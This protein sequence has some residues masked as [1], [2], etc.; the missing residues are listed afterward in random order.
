MATWFAQNSSVNIDSVNQWNSAANGSGSWLTWASLAAGDVLVANGKTSIAINVNVTCATLTTAATGGTAGGGFIL[1]AGVNITAN[2]DCGTTT[3]V[4][5]SAAGGSNCIITG[6]LTGST[7]TGSVTAYWHSSTGT[8]NIVGNVVGGTSSGFGA[9]VSNG[10]VNITGNVT[11]GGAGN[12]CYGINYSA[13]SLAITGNVTGGTQIYSY[14]ILAA[15]SISIVIVGDII[16]S[17]T[18][19][20]IGLVGAVLGTTTIL[21]TG[22][23]QGSSGGIVPFGGSHKYLIHA[24]NAQQHGYYTN[25]SGTPGVLRTLYTG[26]VNL[27]QPAVANVRSGTTFGAASEYT[28]TLAVPSASLVAVGV[29]TD[30]TTGTYNPQ[31][32]LLIDT[33]IAT[34]ASQT[35]F[36][37]TA[38]SADDDTYNDKTMIITD[39]VTSA[40]KA[41]VTVSDY[42]GSTKTITLSAS[43][44]FTIATGDYVAV[45]A[46]ASSSG[47]GG[48]DAA[49]VRSAIGLASA[50]LDT[51]LSGIS[52]KTTNLPSDPAD[53]SVIIAATDAILTAVG[54]RS[55]QTSVDDLPTN[56]ELATALGTADDAVLAAIA[57]VQS[58]TNDIQTRL[59]AALESGRIAAVL[60][61]AS[62]LAIWNTLT[63]ETFT[64]DSFGDLLIISDGTNG[65][66][67]KVT[68]AN[69]IAADVHD[70]QPDGL[71]ASTDIIAIKAKTTNLPTDPA[72]Q[73]LVEAAITAA[74][75]PLA[76]PA[77]V[78]AQVLDVLSVDTF[79]ELSSPPAATSSLKDKLGWL[80]MW[81]RNRSTQ[82][83][84]QR[85]LYAD[86]ATTIV[87]TE[88]VGDDGATFTKGEA[89]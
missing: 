32:A 57:T 49:G 8:T 87:S 75:S 51:Q 43:P 40:Q 54:T 30:A 4:T 77:Q 14:G 20:A 22:H 67:V 28:G 53:Q 52:D 9:T 3:C 62:R 35:S 65:R 73:S 76:T 83:A 13:G 26:G 44:G 15:A 6:N 23:I 60:D 82:S 17:A 27:G 58:D 10:V 56:A 79:G 72:D 78:N 64:A 37:L 7:T 80:F 29:A 74:T 61:S 89:S 86:D 59:P 42:T 69:H 45:I 55:S 19:P 36:T 2:I 11:G 88:T 70:V 5:R 1:S 16:P 12:I 31:P 50:N 34:L 66:A 68:G 33:T 47:G 81:A 48:L 39:Q 38:G 63:T 41:V 46:G 24:T 71:T 84:T 21:H 25:V 85:K 18:T